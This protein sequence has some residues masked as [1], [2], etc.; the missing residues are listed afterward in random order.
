MLLQAKRKNMVDFSY[1]IN[2]KEEQHFD[3]INSLEDEALS[4]A[5]KKLETEIEN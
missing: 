1:K 2:V 5:R 3:E 4:V